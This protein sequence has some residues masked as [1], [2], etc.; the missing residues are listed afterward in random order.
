MTD[1]ESTM[2]GDLSYGDA[3]L[4]PRQ[5]PIHQ[6]M[7]WHG[8]QIR[9]WNHLFHV[10]EEEVSVADLTEPLVV[11]F[12]KVF[13]NSFDGIS[14][15]EYWLSNN[16][17]IFGVEL[18]IWDYFLKS[19][20][21]TPFQSSLSLLVFPGEHWRRLVET[22]KDVGVVSTTITKMI[23]LQQWVRWISHCKEEKQKS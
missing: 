12:K 18:P 3:R 9:Q 20:S 15:E 1:R 17:L 10:W 23:T 6:T 13:I 11:T 2:V 16:L 4:H 5:I 22:K 19:Q 8:L 14:K 21:I 7:K